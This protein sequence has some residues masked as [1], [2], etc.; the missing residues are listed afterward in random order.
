MGIS[1]FL[2]DLFL[3]YVIFIVF[4]LKAPRISLNKLLQKAP[5][6][7]PFFVRVF[8]VV[9]FFGIF[10]SR[11]I[12]FDWEGYSLFIIILLYLVGIISLPLLYYSSNKESYYY[13]D[14]LSIFTGFYWSMIENLVANSLFNE[15]LCVVPITICLSLVISG[16]LDN[17]K[18]ISIRDKW[19]FFVKH[20]EDIILFLINYVI[21][22]F[23]HKHAFIN[24]WLIYYSRYIFPYP[25]PIYLIP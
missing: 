17:N 12:L 16:L 18:Y 15:E 13:G 6:E 9:I 1:F 4:A 7:S 8:K 24:G 22:D 2:T 25:I 19:L 10:I 21:R 14:L 20:K 23:H 11:I 3:F 5:V